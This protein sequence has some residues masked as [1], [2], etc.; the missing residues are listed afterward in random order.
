MRRD[1]CDLGRAEGRGNYHT[2]RQLYQVPQQQS[3]FL[4]EGSLHRSTRPKDGKRGQFKGINSVSIS[5]IYKAL[6][7]EWISFRQSMSAGRQEK[8]ADGNRN[9]EKS[10][11]VKKGKLERRIEA[12]Q[13]WKGDTHLPTTYLTSI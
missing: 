10:K 5:I 6:A 2:R 7:V 8:V 4:R 12:G 11:T 13:R 9:S 1:H 3:T